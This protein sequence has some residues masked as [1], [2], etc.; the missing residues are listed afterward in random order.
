[1]PAGRF[2][3]AA[4]GQL[5]R[6]N[7]QKQAEVSGFLALQCLGFQSCKDRHWVQENCIK[8][9]TSL[10]QKQQ[11]KPGKAIFKQERYRSRSKLT[12]EC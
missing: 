3:Q 9:K 1:M 2:L 12:A 6:E 5:R 10:N 11:K 4:A 7:R 8:C